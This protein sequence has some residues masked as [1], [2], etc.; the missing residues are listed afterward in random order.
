M[1]ADAYPCGG[2]PGLSRPDA[3]VAAVRRAV[4]ELGGQQLVPRPVRG[5][6][7]EPAQCQHLTIAV[8][9][10]LAVTS[11]PFPVLHS[12]L[13]GAHYRSD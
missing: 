10:V 3:V 5:H 8:W 4:G 7:Q 11:L 9:R 13:E 6:T 2:V 12:L 1:A